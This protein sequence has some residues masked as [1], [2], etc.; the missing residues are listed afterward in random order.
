MG[1]TGVPDVGVGAISTAIGRTLL[2]VGLE[3]PGSDMLPAFKGV[4]EAIATRGT[5]VGCVLLVRLAIMPHRRKAPNVI[6]QKGMRLDIGV[7][8]YAT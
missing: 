4:V 8:L 1:S 5:A 3:E 7:R 2:G 6:I